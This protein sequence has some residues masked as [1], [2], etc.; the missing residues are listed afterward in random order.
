MNSIKTNNLISEFSLSE[1]ISEKTKLFKQIWESFSSD[2]PEVQSLSFSTKKQIKQFLSTQEEKRIIYATL[3]PIYRWDSV[4]VENIE[5]F[6]DIPK[7]F[8]IKADKMLEAISIISKCASSKVNL[9]LADRW[10]IL[11]QEISSNELGDNIKK[12]SEI[13]LNQA[14]KMLDN[15]PLEIKTFTEL[16][17]PI[18]RVSIAN[19]KIKKQ[20]ILNLLCKYDIDAKKFNSQIDIIIKSFWLWNAYNLIK[21]YLEENEFFINNFENIAFLNTEFCRALNSLYTAS[22]NPNKRINNN[23]LF[24]ALNLIFNLYNYEL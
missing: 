8:Q 7:R 10:I 24:A 19:E 20:D 21:N 23:N 5:D 16:G 22:S 1:K 13:Y 18:E 14:K 17:I 2:D 3:C 12:T 6:S 11:P 15:I 4:S 9:L